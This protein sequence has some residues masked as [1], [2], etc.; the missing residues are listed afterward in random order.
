MESQAFL[1]AQYSL[2]PVDLIPPEEDE[3]AEVDER[4][5]R[6]ARLGKLVDLEDVME[7]VLC[8]LRESTQLRYL[9]E[10]A[11]ADPHDTNKPRVHINDALRMAQ[12]VLVEVVTAV[13]EQISVLDVV[14]D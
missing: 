9:I 11:I 8:R 14:E 10:D 13:D 4:Q 1:P 5:A 12:D 6:Y 3:A 2:S 7:M